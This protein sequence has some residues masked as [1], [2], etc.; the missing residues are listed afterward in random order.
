MRLAILDDNDK[1]EVEYSEK[2]FRELLIKYFEVH[3]D[4]EKSFDQ[5]VSDL[6]DKYENG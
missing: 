6:R 4:I 3:K 2:I 5:L 1:V